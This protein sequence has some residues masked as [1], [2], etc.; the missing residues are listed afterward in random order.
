MERDA[1]VVGVVN[2]ILL[3]VVLFWIGLLALAV[4]TLGLRRIA[5][6]PWEQ[7]VLYLSIGFTTLPALVIGFGYCQSIAMQWSF[8]AAEGR[9]QRLIVSERLMGAPRSRVLAF[10]RRQE[11]RGT[12][13]THHPPMPY[14]TGSESAKPL[15]QQSAFRIRTPGVSATRVGLVSWISV[16]E[17]HFDQNDR[18]IN[19]RFDR[20]GKT[21]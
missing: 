17:L 6:S 15:E 21:L 3:S 19:Y 7:F 16:I 11:V 2:G 4:Y 9:F 1:I 14:P 10:V 13:H 12:I 20:E 8:K 5:I 18:L